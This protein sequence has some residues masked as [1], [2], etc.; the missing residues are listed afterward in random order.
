MSLQERWELRE[1]GQARKA[2]PG[3][4]DRWRGHLVGSTPGPAGATLGCRQC[5]C[6]AG[7]V[8][9]SCKSV[10]V[11]LQHGAEKVLCAQVPGSLGSTPELGLGLGEERSRA[12]EL[13]KHESRWSPVLLS[14]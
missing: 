10:A 13:G 3:R 12:S 4:E 2:A 5:G 8:Q 6:V 9:C 7:D 14:E 1:G 11:M